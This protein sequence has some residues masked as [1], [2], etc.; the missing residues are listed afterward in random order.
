M[1]LFL[2]GAL[3]AGALLL[4]CTSIPPEITSKKARRDFIGAD[5]GIPDDQ[6]KLAVHYYNGCHGA[7]R[8]YA[9]AYK[10]FSAA[11]SRER[12]HNDESGSGYSDALYW[13]G[14]MLLEAE[15]VE[16]DIEQAVNQYLLPAANR[17]HLGAKTALGDYYLYFEKNFAE[18][19]KLLTEAYEG[20]DKSAGY[21]L[22]VMYLNGN[23]VPENPIV[24]RS[25]LEGA[26]DSG[27]LNTAFLLG[28]IY[29]DGLGT[30][31]DL[32]IARS[33]YERAAND[34]HHVAPEALKR[35][36]AKVQ[37]EEQMRQEVR[38]QFCPCVG[39]AIHVRSGTI[40]AIVVD[41]DTRNR[42]SK[43]PFLSAEA[44]SGAVLVTVLVNF[45]NI[46]QQPISGFSLPTIRLGSP[47]GAYYDAD[48][49]KSSAV[50]GILEIDSKVLSDLNPG[51]RSQALA[52]FEVSEE[53]W[54]QPGW[55]ATIDSS[56]IFGR[57]ELASVYLEK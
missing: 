11:T 17:G 32:S 12:W 28:S 3:C 33:W 40:E 48:I 31:P 39:D 4:A 47:G 16:Q 34:G 27:P 52:V 8:D 29:E 23:G 2:A 44:Q 49:G 42:F 56:K 24:A 51:L 54:E 43:G 35:V 38:A 15:G 13:R 10:W 45:R 18:A 46:S 22:G 57:R 6:Y 30:D 9:K 7:P 5:V 19:K 53:L 1:K 50:A 21:D 20:G 26:V 25:Y 36:E 37:A 55:R 41:V 14:Y